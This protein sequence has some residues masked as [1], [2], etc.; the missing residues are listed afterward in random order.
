MNQIDCEG[1]NRRGFIKIG[2]SAFNQNCARCHGAQGQGGIGPVLNDQG[3]L[4]SHLTPSYIQNVLTVGGRYVCGNPMSLMGV[5]A[6]SN[7]GP[8]NY[9]QIQELIAWIRATKDDKIKVLDPATG[10]TVE[11]TGWRDTTYVPAPDATP[12]PACWSSA[13]SSPTPMP[14]GGGGSPTRLARIQLPRITGDVRYCGT[15]LVGV[16]R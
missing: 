14:S 3:K 8:L 1:N 6:D 15:E 4:L 5:W 16:H 9:R 12:V 11:V 13:F 7:G 10:A 2:T